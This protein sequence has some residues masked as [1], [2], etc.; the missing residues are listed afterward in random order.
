[1]ASVKF[2]R[3]IFE[4]EIG[5][6]TEDLQNKIALFGTTVENLDEKEIELDVTPDRPDLL[7]YQGFKRSFLCFL[8]KKSGLKKYKVFPLEKNFEVKINSSVKAVRPFT[9][10]A[11]VKGLKLND[12]KI[13]E[14][15][16]IQEKLHSTI[17]RRRKKNGTRNLSFR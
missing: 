3:K 9:V 2:N 12:E 8:G 6:L 11:I 4:K 16:E 14:L 15:I 13:K 7:S 5:K 1:M 17:G 10:C